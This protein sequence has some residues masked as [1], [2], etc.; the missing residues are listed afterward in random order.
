MNTQTQYMGI[1][2]DSP[3]IVG[4]CGLSSS[5]ENLEYMQESG[6]GAVILKSIFEEQIIYDIKRNANVIA[7]TDNYG[8]SYEYIAAHVAIDSLSQYFDYIRKARKK[9]QIPIVGSIHCYSF[10]NWLT[11]AKRFE[12]AG[13]NALE[14]NMAILPYE[15]TISVDD[16]ERLFQNV[17]QSLKK[18]VS[19]PV[20]VKLSHNFTDMAKF[21]QQ[22]SWTGINSITLFNKPLYIDID[23]STETL[24]PAPKLSAPE[25]L[26]NTLRW[27]AIL[28]K[29]VRCELS[30][31]T[32]VYSA[33][34][35]VKLLLAGAQTVQVVSCLYKHGIDHIKTLNDGL[36]SWME[37]ND[38]NS[39]DQFR[40][41]LAVKANDEA[42]V[43]FR[44][45]FMKYF[46]E[47]N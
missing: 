9:L 28:S 37:A 32:G 40:G 44:T 1:T 17:I 11:Y 23:T 30:A 21:M 12:D 47:I 39:I 14:L 42:S 25:E 43:L 38:Y 24:Q 7:P 15:T 34:D 26:F 46:A 29:K 6:V 5:L 31:S 13:C 27:I 3:V 36:R 10:E 8:D 19:I 18:F 35:V 33:D 20:S 4:S 22:L 41:K 2:V 45:Q 16:I